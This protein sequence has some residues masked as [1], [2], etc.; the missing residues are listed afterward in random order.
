[1]DRLTFEGNFCCISTCENMGNGCPCEGGGCAT[2]KVW[3][4]L[5][6]FEDLGYT[7][8]AL[9]KLVKFDKI[10]KRT[11]LTVDRIYDL[12]VADETGRVAILPCKATPDW[13]LEREKKRVEFW[14]R[15]YE[16]CI[17]LKARVGDTL[18]L[19]ASYFNDQLTKPLA[20]RVTR[21]VIGEDDA[22]TYVTDKRRISAEALGKT[23]FLNKGETE[24][25]LEARK[26][27]TS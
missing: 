20:A 2:K 24:K 7:P 25:A 11:G 8:A 21:I 16:K 26:D 27:E 5:R 6:E 14:K 12:I 18:W 4:R 10:M 15:K 17:H 22:V 13:Q 1:M 19:T 23:V 3:D 9:A